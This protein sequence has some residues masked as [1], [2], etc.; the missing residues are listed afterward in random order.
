MKEKHIVFSEAGDVAY[1]SVN[2]FIN[3]DN[4]KKAV[5]EQNQEEL[6]IVE[7]IRIEPCISTLEGIPAETIF[8]LSSTDA[9]IKNYF[10]ADVSEIGVAGLEKK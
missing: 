1:G 8:P 3:S 2:D 5:I 4:F 7:N 10:V 9:V 6:C